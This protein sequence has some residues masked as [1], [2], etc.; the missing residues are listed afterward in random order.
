MPARPQTIRQISDHLC[1]EATHLHKTISALSDNY[2][3]PT[4]LALT[5]YLL[6]TRSALCYIHGGDPDPAIPSTNPAGAAIA[7]WW[8]HHHPEDWVDDGRRTRHA[9]QIYI[10]LHQLMLTS[11]HATIPQL[12]RSLGMPRATAYWVLAH[13][14]RTSWANLEKI[15]TSLGAHRDEMWALWNRAYKPPE[16]TTPVASYGKGLSRR[17]A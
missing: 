12:A 15:V 5:N 14:G 8:Q 3:D 4:R 16:K 17:R 2:S 13:P 10:T 7:E 9:E 6:G 1:A 11:P